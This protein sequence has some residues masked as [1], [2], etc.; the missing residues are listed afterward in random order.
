MKKLFITILILAL[1]PLGIFAKFENTHVNTGDALEDIIAIAETQLGYMEGNL[2]GEVQGHNDRTKYGVWYPMPDNPWCAMFVSWC[3]EQAGISTSVIPKHA[4]CD[5]GMQWFVNKGLFSFAPYYGGNYTPNRGDIVYFG[6]RYGSGFDSTHVG[7]VY[8]V[9]SEMV[10]VIEGNS[11][12]KVQTVSYK[13]G[14]SYIIGYGKPDYAGE[15][16]EPEP[17]RYVTTAS[18]LNFRAEP[19]TTSSVLGQL[20][21][22]TEVDIVEIA[23]SKWGKTTYQGKTGWISLDYCTRAFSVIYNANGGSSAPDTQIKFPSSD[24]KLS[25]AKP[26]REG[27]TFL[28]WSSSPEGE[29]EY[30]TGD[31]YSENLS[32][33]LYAVWQINTYTVIYNSNSGAGTPPSQTKKHGESITLPTV[34]REGYRFLGW[35][36]TDKGVVEYT[37]TYSDNKD[38]TLYAVW[39]IDKAKFTVTY[40]ANGGAHAP[41]AQTMTEGESI[42][43]TA[44]VPTKSGYTF[45]GWAYSANAD[46]AEL[47]PGNI[48]DTNASVTLYAVWSR[49]VSGLSLSVGKGGRVQRSV[50]GDI[51]TLRITANEGNSI[52]Y[53]SVD[54]IPMGLTGDMTEYTVTLDTAVHKVIVEFTYNDGLWIDPFDDV[55]P[56]AWYYKAV[57]YCYTNNIMTGMD[58]THFAPNAILTRG[59]FV[60]LLGRLHGDVTSSGSLVFTDVSPNHYYYKYLVWAYNNK[61]VSGT[62]PDKFSPNQPITREQLCVMLFNYK[63]YSGNI[64]DYNPILLKD[65]SDNEIISPWAQDAF[66]WTVYNKYITG[67]NGML[68]PRN[69][70][71]RAQAAQIIMGFLNKKG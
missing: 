4:S 12:D 63:K 62:A 43:L 33:T 68:L 49:T 30:M 19:D 15:I 26:L 28:G 23:N 60:T 21:Y 51:L 70:A 17:G 32:I 39:E 3:A 58:A 36:T 14:I 2:S 11:S 59:Q 10:H 48:Y 42:L 56:T 27:Y 16:K 29:V 55:A 52:S 41:A 66:A 67:A 44:S 47:F 20:P 31:V 54:G 71:T 64:G 1:L 45:E 57:E 5:V 38:I 37:D 65:Y 22:G 34:E 18:M 53:I 35:S 25:Q 69:N 13:L 9:D 8:K 40:N 24:L 61:L 50:S 6:S 46:L 7:I